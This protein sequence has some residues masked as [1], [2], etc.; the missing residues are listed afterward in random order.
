[1]DPPAPC[2][3]AAVQRPHIHKTVRRAVLLTPYL[4]VWYGETDERATGDMRP[5]SV[6]ISRYPDRGLCGWGIHRR[7]AGLRTAKPPLLSTWV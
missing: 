4:D 7:S 2:K 5:L 3:N 6:R 1:M